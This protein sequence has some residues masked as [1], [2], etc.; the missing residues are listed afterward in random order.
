MC[1]HKFNVPLRFHLTQKAEKIVVEAFCGVWC[2]PV[3]TCIIP[4]IHPPVK[5]RSGYSGFVRVF[6][7]L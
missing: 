2:C 4:E 6:Y 3:H 7:G 1:L 5:G